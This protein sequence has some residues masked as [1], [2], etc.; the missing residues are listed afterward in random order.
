MK[1]PDQKY[2][3]DPEHRF[4]PFERGKFLPF[5]P[6]SFDDRSRKGL[7]SFTQLNNIVNDVSEA[8]RQLEAGLRKQHD[9]EPQTRKTANMS[10]D[11]VLSKEVQRSHLGL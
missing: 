5:N 9:M 7:D 6:L 4:S 1:F 10:I 2:L 3:M 11:N 8:T